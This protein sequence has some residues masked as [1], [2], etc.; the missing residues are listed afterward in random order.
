MFVEEGFRI[1]FANG[2]VIDFYADSA[3][4]KE[5]WMQVLGETVGKGYSAG[6]GKAKAWTELVMRREK[7]ISAKKDTADR[8]M[9]RP[10]RP[11]GPGPGSAHAGP[12]APPRP[13][14]PPPA[15][16]AMGPPPMKHPMAP[17]PKPRHQHNQS[18]PEAGIQRQGARHQKARS[19]IF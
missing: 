13:P 2:E 7:N 4:E 1:R 5:G 10:V 16:E 11:N 15:K 8:R 6:T 12:V 3:A 17:P 19:L 18:Q 9:S 14:P